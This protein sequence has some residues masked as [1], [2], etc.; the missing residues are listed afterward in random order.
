[1]QIDMHYCG[2][3]AMG[4]AAGL[5][6]EA[7]AQIATASQLVDDNAEEEQVEFG[8]GGR[9]D[10]MS[11]AR[12]TN[13]IENWDEEMQRKVWVPFHL[14]PSDIMGTEFLWEPGVSSAR[15]GTPFALIRFP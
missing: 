9:M 11:T 3:D 12:H 1:M 7:S 8:D 10:L 5:T 4:R 14:A 15:H 6:K 2:V 13:D